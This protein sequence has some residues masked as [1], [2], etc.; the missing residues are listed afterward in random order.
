MDWGSLIEDYGPCMVN[1]PLSEASTADLEADYYDLSLCP[2]SVTSCHKTTVQNNLNGAG[3]ENC[4]SM[5]LKI[6]A[7]LED[8]D[9]EDFHET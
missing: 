8:T 3:A 5:M 1:Q 4:R 7:S 2:L 9:A 6:V